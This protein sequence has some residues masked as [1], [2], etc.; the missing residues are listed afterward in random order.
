MA[1]YLAKRG[2]SLMWLR[3]PTV[4][5]TLAAVVLC[6]I[7]IQAATPKD[8]AEAT[9][10]YT[11]APQY[12][13]TAWLHAGERFPDGAKLMLRTGST[14][15]PLIGD[16]F[17]SADPH[18]SFDGTTILFAGKQQQGDHWQIWEMPVAGGAPKKVTSCDDDCITPFYLPDERFVYAR[19]IHGDFQLEAAPRAGGESVRLT[20][21]PGDSIPTDV[22]HDGRILFESTYPMG[23]G[24][25][26]ELYTVYP[27]GSGV[28]SYRCDHGKNRHSG[29]Q[30]ASGDIVFV[31]E[32]GLG[33]FTSPLAH[34]VE[35]KAPSGEFAGDT[36][37]NGENIWIIS[38]RATPQDHYSFKTWNRETNTVRTLVIENGV[39]VVQPRLITAHP[40]PN[41]FP[42]ALHDWKG[43]N[44]LCLDAYTSKLNIAAGSLDSVK[45]YTLRDGQT[46]L[47]GRAHVERDGS[48][49][50][51]VPGDQPLQ[52]ELLDAS[53]KTVQREHGW[54]WMRNGEQRV[55]VGCH[56]G[57]ERSP[58]NAVPEVLT[59]STEPADMTQTQVAN[60]QGG[61]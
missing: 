56:A 43:A 32:H 30:M 37:E 31:S 52:M 20:Y 47:L 10:I 54:F 26:A 27:D 59:K 38:S 12:L 28:E 2:T 17:A 14:A 11:S 6:F 61:R 21:L 51:H 48:F 3:T 23:Q 36:I 44:V 9:L 34:E 24:G 7:G 45:V 8:V 18:V 57:P 35:I 5:L 22:L 4:V 1:L 39:D 50:L 41:R 42:S 58:E 40:I 46:V 25:T 29:R 53:G 33:R 55:C 13:V 16:F 49:F 19:K 60:T 15:H